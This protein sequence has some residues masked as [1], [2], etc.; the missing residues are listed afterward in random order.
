MQNYKILLFGSGFTARAITDFYKNLDNFFVSIA[1]NDMKSASE[2]ASMNPKNFK[3]VAVD[4][5][6]VETFEN[7]I[8][9]CDIAISLI[10]ATLH[11]KVAEVC[12]KYSKH[13]VTSSYVSPAM[14][15]LDAQVRA[16][17]LTFLNEIGL[18]PGIDH[19]A[20]MSS[21]NH[22][23]SNGGVVQKYYSFTGG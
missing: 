17:G 4:V 18:D 9:E 8:Q 7:L 20:T 23:K 5:M 22:I 19:L 12:I 21:L 16:K 10:P 11:M 14:Q 2:L 13:L 1:S 3:A 6:K 15:A